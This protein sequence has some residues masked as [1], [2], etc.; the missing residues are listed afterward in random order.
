MEKEPF[1][2]KNNKINQLTAKGHTRKK[3]IKNTQFRIKQEHLLSNIRNINRSGSGT[4]NKILYQQ[5]M[6]LKG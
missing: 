6:L 5:V 3:D 1:I 4:R 2:E